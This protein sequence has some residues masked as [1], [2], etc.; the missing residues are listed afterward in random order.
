MATYALIHGAGAE[1]QQL[2]GQ[3]GADERGGVAAEGLGDHDDLAPV[4]DRLQDDVGV[5]GQAGRLI[6]ARQVRCDDVVPAPLQL[7]GH[8]VPVP[9]HVAGMIPRPDE[10]AAEM[11]A[12][13]GYAEALAAAGGPDA[14]GDPVAVFYHDVPPA[15][16]EE[17]LGRGRGQAAGKRR[18]SRQ[19]R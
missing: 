18:S 1:H 14:A 16:A 2:R 4:A 10:T 5:V 19:S 6:L 9:A 15:L 11:F 8:Q 13:T 12:A 17:A 7:G 3:P